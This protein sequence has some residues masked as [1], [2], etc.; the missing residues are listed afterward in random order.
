[1]RRRILLIGFDISFY[2]RISKILANDYAVN[3]AGNPKSLSK[4]NP[5]AILLYVSKFK[6]GFKSLKEIVA[7]DEDIP[8]LIID[9]TNALYVQAA[10]T[11]LKLGAFD[12]MPSVILPGILKS[13]IAGMLQK[14]DE[15]LRV[16]KKLRD[17]HELLMEIVKKLPSDFEPYGKRSRKN[18]SSPDCS[19]SCKHYI[20]LSGNLRHDWGVCVNPKGPRCGLMTFEHMG[21]GEF[22][23]PELIFPGTLMDVIT[24]T[25]PKKSQLNYVETATDIIR[26]SIGDFYDI[27][28]ISGNTY[29]GTCIKNNKSWIWIGFTSFGFSTSSKFIFQYPVTLGNLDAKGWTKIDRS[30]DKNKNHCFVIPI[31]KYLD[32]KGIEKLCGIICNHAETLLNSAQNDDL[33][34][35]PAKCVH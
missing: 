28:N 34:E 2:D 29:H 31:E 5:D 21:C 27:S 13:T 4:H 33:I 35:D 26:Q 12:I 3:S 18:G 8:A 22:E 10:I 14:R 20:E 9:D 6:E 25:I 30:S 16:K 15:A 23:S 32:Q 1:M 7:S 24:H 17:K 11:F 19:C